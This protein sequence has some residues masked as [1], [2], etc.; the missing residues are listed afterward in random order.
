MYNNKKENTMKI[1]KGQYVTT[2]KST[3]GDRSYCGDTLQVAA[4]SGNYVT[5]KRLYNSFGSISRP[6]D[7][8]ITLDVREWPIVGL[9]NDHLIAV[10]IL[11]TDEQELEGLDKKIECLTQTLNSLEQTPKTKSSVTRNNADLRRRKKNVYGPSHICYCGVSVGS[12]QCPK[13]VG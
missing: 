5:L 11:L 4:I 1:E 12:C 2:E 7:G 3:R 10:G 9:S 13:E 8:P 6:N